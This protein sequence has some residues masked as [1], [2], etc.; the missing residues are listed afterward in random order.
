MP[1]PSD[2]SYRQIPLSQGQFATI[3]AKNH[4]R[5]SAFKW[6]AKWNRPTQ[7]FYAVRRE[8]EAP[9]RQVWM[10]REVLGLTREDKARGDHRDGN[11]LNNIERNLRRATS[12][13]NNQNAKR[14]KDNTSGF[15]GVMARRGRYEV[16]TYINGKRCQVGTAD[17]LAMA[18]L[19]YC[20]AATLTFGEFARMS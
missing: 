9:R 17:S 5:F 18:H 4:Q 7:S 13:Q 11:T 20:I 3:D 6:T 15:K 12:A 8:R 10:H 14:R 16:R 2:S 19:M 1:T